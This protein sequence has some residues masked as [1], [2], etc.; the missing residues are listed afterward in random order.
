MTHCSLVQ[1]SLTKAHTHPQELTEIYS[2]SFLVIAMI[3][4]RQ[5]A[6][7]YNKQLTNQQTADTRVIMVSVVPSKVVIHL[8]F[9]K[10]Y[11]KSSPGFSKCQQEKIQFEKPYEVTS[12]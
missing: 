1:I 7:M 8:A 5:V 10:S 12:Q 4:S 11:S 6:A 9:K 2:M 3:S